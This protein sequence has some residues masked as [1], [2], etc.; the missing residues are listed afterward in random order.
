MH[1]AE[2]VHAVSKGED[3]E[4]VRKDEDGEDV[5]FTAQLVMGLIIRQIPPESQRNLGDVERERTGC[6]EGDNR[7]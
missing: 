1:P 6:R 4:N 5:V 3:K 7:M 2:D